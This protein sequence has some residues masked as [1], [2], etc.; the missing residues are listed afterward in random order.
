MKASTKNW[1]NFLFLFLTLGV[2]FYLGL[3]GNDLKSLARA[4]HSISPLY[5]GLCLLA[6]AG[7]M[8]MDALTIFYFLHRQNYQIS[9]W[10]AIYLSI[11]GVYYAD[12]TPG[13]SGGQPV[14][15]YRMKQMGV[16]IGVSGSCLTVKFA[17]FQLMLLVVGTVLW[18]IYRDFVAR[19]VAGMYWFIWLGY[20]FNFI[21]IGVLLLMSISKRVM[22]MLITVCIHIG[23]KLRIC[24]DPERSFAK[25]EAHCISFSQSV[26]MIRN[27]PGEL[28]VQ[29]LIA[30]VQLFML[31]SIT[32]AI[33]HSFG[34]HT[35]SNMEVITMGVLLYISASY[36][37]LPGGSGAMEGGFAVFFKGIFPAASLFVGLV[38]WR[39]GTYYISLAMGVF[40]SILESIRAFFGKR[41]KKPSTIPAS[42]PSQTPKEPADTEKL[43]QQEGVSHPKDNS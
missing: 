1:L 7:Y 39:S 9:L 37:P 28:L 14:Q 4:L 29:C 3:S 10:K 18:I 19:H 42:G 8:L 32:L 21:S 2:V 43:T 22:M 35:A 15:I 38:I 24:K 6:W 26:K 40:V 23:V 36:T 25:W 20:L 5:L 41:A 11:I 31:M 12:I 13:A 34:L 16:P 17:C 30:V 27:H 33:Y